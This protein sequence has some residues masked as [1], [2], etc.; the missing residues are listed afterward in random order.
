M[1]R[2]KISG[3]FRKI[4]ETGSAIGLHGSP[5]RLKNTVHSV[6]LKQGEKLI[7]RGRNPSGVY[8]TLIDRVQLEWYVR[9]NEVERALNRMRTTMFNI[10]HVAMR[11]GN[12]RFTLYLFNADAAL[13]DN[14]K[15]D[16]KRSTG[17]FDSIRLV[18]DE[19]QV[20]VIPKNIL[21]S[22]DYGDTEISL[23]HSRAME[24]KKQMRHAGKRDG[25]KRFAAYL[26]FER[27]DLMLC[28]TLEAIANSSVPKTG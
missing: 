1:E 14:P 23:V 18:E 25:P 6:G 4:V 21:Y 27:A 3:A 17:A 16:G 5:F 7:D 8:F 11:R 20:P 2:Q 15:H 24:L 12:A 28:R 13:R 26:K 9:T 10:T 19:S 22:L